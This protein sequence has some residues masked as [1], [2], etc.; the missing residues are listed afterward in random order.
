M[1]TAGGIVKFR[2]LSMAL[3]GVSL[4]SACVDVSVTRVLQPIATT[5]RVETNSEQGANV[6]GWVSFE[7]YV[8]AHASKLTVTLYMKYEG[9]KLVVAKQVYQ[10]SHLPVRYF[11]AVAPI[12]SGQGHMLL[13]AKLEVNGR[14]KG[15][16]SSDYFYHLGTS[17]LDLILKP[18]H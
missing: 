16:A 7:N 4:L 12:Q 3:M 8:P 14:L 2:Q 11:F 18:S 15:V 5:N 6:T 17:K 10:N 9:Q 1:V 13:E